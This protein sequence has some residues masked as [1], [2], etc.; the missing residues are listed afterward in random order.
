MRDMEWDV[1]YQVDESTTARF[2]KQGFVKLPGVLDAA[3]IAQ[4]EPEITGRLIDLNTMH[5]P[6][7]QRTTYQKSFLQVGNLWRHSEVVREFAFSRRLASIAAQL[8]K[9]K[10]VRLYHDQALYK[11]AGGGVTPWHADQYYWPFASD[12][13]CTVWIPLQETPLEMGP[14]SFSPGSHLFEFGRDL[15]I[16]DDS[17]AA[18]QEA[19]RQQDFPL[20]QEPY[21]LGE[22]SYHQGWTF[23]RAEQNLS[24][25]PRRVMTMIYMDADITV[26]EP[27]NTEQEKDRQKWLE[28]TPVGM[29]PDTETNPVLYQAD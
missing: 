27:S 23:H 28:H 1:P 5:L 18:M 22:V 11:E 24:T 15:P 6:M 19:L 4:Y 21:T 20:S 7:D 29:V 25:T 10:S 14:L 17:E 26:A 3:T 12:R 2:E 13:I 9:V 8:M 16:S